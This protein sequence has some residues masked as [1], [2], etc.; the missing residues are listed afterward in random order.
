M[1]VRQLALLVNRFISRFPLL[2]RIET[3]W[4]S[5]DRDPAAKEPLGGDSL[6]AQSRMR[7]HPAES[8]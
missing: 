2:S 7:S 4:L 3:L 8:R 5:V 1:L 6:L